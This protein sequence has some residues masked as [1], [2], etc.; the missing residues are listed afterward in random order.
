MR[1]GGPA[2]LWRHGGAEGLCGR[3]RPPR[4]AALPPAALRGA[5]RL[6]GMPTQRDSSSTMAAPGGG[7]GGLGGDSAHQ[8]RVKA[9][10]K[11]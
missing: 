8:V 3:L 10:Y 1:Q 4:P 9:Y 11:G 5:A 6:G 2:A 7:G